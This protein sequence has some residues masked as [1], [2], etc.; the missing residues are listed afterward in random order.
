MKLTF[1]P[2]TV[3]CRTYR[4]ATLAGPAALGPYRRAEAAVACAASAAG[5]NYHTGA[6][7][8]QDYHTGASAGACNA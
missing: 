2:K 5:R 8:G 4:C 1:A 7:A 6:A 3:V